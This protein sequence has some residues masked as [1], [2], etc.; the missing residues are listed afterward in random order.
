MHT[1]SSE[2]VTLTIH[3]EQIWRICVNPPSSIPLIE[4]QLEKQNFLENTKTLSAYFASTPFCHTLAWVQGLEHLFNM[5]VSS[6]SQYIRVILCEG[7]RIIEHLSALGRI[8]NSVGVIPLCVQTQRIRRQY[9]QF[10]SQLGIGASLFIPGGTNIDFRSELIAAFIQFFDR[11]PLIRNDINSKLLDSRIFADR[12]TKLAPISVANVNEL[13]LT[14]TVARASGVTFDVRHSIANNELYSN[15]P[16]IV[17]RSG[18]VYARTCIRIDE[19]AQSLEIMNECFNNIPPE[20]LSY[21]PN[22]VDSRNQRIFFT[23]ED[24]DPEQIDTSVYPMVREYSAVEA[25]EGE[26]GIFLVGNGENRLQRCQLNCPSFYA[27][28]ALEDIAVG[29]DPMD[30]ELIAASLGLAD[31]SLF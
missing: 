1:I 21:K 31:L 25:P 23:K 22:I 24:L 11:I 16:A 10:C 4:K 5:Q 18:D 9:E 2:S 15:F 7:E 8:A 28:Q 30:V 29:E 14:G 17:S 12:A 6:R 13:S 26:F 19:I 27:M 20:D 3:D